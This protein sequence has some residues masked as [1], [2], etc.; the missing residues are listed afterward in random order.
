MIIY[1]KQMRANVSFTQMNYY[2]TISNYDFQRQHLWFPQTQ[3]WFKF[4]T[5]AFW[6]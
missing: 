3:S 5:G 1:P 2:W 6:S 4:G